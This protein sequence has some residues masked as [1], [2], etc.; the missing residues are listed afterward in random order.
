MDTTRRAAGL[1]TALLLGALSVSACGDPAGPAQAAPAEQ[2]SAP[3][4][5][6]RADTCVPWMH[7]GAFQACILRHAATT[8]QDEPGPDGAAGR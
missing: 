2:A 6:Y 1:A 3:A 5:G 7:E 4:I 8:T